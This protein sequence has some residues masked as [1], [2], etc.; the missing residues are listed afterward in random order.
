[1]WALILWSVLRRRGSFDT[2]EPIDAG[3]GQGWIAI[4]GFA[5][6]SI[7]LF[8]F[9]ILS[10]RG[11]AEF[12]MHEDHAGPHAANPE[13]RVIGHQWW[14]E[15]QYIGGPVDRQFTTANEIHVPVGIPVNIALETADVLHSF[16]VPKLQ[17]KVDM[18]PGYVNNL[19]LEAARKE[20]IA[21]NVRNI[22]A[23]NTRT[24]PLLLSPSNQ[25]TMRPGAPTWPNP[26]RSLLRRKRCKVW[27]S[28]SRPPARTAIWCAARRLEASSRPT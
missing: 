18:V 3:G 20:P 24:W 15:V 23:H 27:K 19:R 17:G 21:A 1:M 11:M 10:L 7:I 28:F 2:H 13:I 9:F 6:P 4:G 26:H 8:V 25:K 14:W 5:I 22:A 16:W 12:P